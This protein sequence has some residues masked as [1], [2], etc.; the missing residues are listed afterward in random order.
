MLRRFAA[1]CAVTLRSGR[2]IR[3]VQLMK[4][5]DKYVSLINLRYL[6]EQPEIQMQV[7]PLQAA[8]P[9]TQERDNYTISCI[10]STPFSSDVAAKLMAPLN[11]Q[12][13]E[14]KPDG[15]LYLPE[16]K[17]RRTLNFA[18]GPGGWVCS[19]QMPVKMRLICSTGAPSS[20]FSHHR[21]VRSQSRICPLLLWTFSFSGN[22]RTTI[23]RWWNV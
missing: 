14:I 10:S 7:S 13:V 22:W 21:S 6:S 15:L 8:L 18:I 16:I 12:D 1:V 5:T 23:T 20:L 11:P 3:S 19:C 2:S 4:S 9:G 17:Y